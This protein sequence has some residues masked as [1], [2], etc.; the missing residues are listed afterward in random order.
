[1]LFRSAQLGNNVREAVGRED[2]SKAG[3]I[4]EQMQTVLF[5]ALREQ[6]EFVIAQFHDLVSERFAALDKILHDQL[7][8]R[9][10][11][12]IEANDIEELRSV[13]HFL[14]NNR[15]VTATASAKIAI[16]AGLVR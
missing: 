8:V 1:M 3:Q 12:A 11:Q 15:M 2:W 14:I 13:I 10:E 4:F 7:V 16:L 6:P 9:G 5:R